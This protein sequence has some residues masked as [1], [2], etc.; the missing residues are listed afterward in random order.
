MGVLDIPVGDK[1]FRILNRPR[2][3]LHRITAL[4]IHLLLD[5]RYREVVLEVSLVLGGFTCAFPFWRE[6]WTQ[7]QLD[8]AKKRVGYL[9]ILFDPNYK[10]KPDPEPY[11]E[12][13]AAGLY[14]HLYTTEHDIEVIPWEILE[15]ELGPEKWE[16]FSIWIGG[17]TVVAKGPYSWDI[18]RFLRGASAFRF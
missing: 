1:K 12:I 15:R 8:D 10:P 13:K 2:F 6:V 11:R 16:E 14:V 9:H 17:Q 4:G 5:W 7:K 3:E 18:E